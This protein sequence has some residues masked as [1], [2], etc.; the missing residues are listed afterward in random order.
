MANRTC[1]VGSIIM[2][3]G[4]T[5]AIP[6]KWYLCNGSNGTPD[7]RSKFIYAA[8]SDGVVGNNSSTDTAHTHTTTAS[9][10]SGGEHAHWLTY[11]TGTAGAIS[12]AYA[13]DGDNMITSGHTHS[14]T[15]KNS[16]TVSAHSHTISATNSAEGIPPYIR[17]FYIMRGA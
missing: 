15:G 7:L 14:G 17:V 1:P 9:T 3:S 5:S 12:I 8:S 16:N 4:L 13:A 11:S 2:W 10:G 6:D